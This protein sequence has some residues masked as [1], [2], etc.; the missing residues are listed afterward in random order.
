MTQELCD[1]YPCF[2]GVKLTNTEAVASVIERSLGVAMVKQSKKTD[3]ASLDK[4]ALLTYAIQ[5]DMKWARMLLKIRSKE[6]V[7]SS[8]LDP[9]P[10]FAAYDGRIR[11]HV[12]L[13]TSVAGRWS[14]TQPA[15][16]TLPRTKEIHKLFVAGKGKRML[17]FD[18][19][20]IELRSGCSIANEPRMIKAYNNNEDIHRLTASS[21]YEIQLDDVNDAQ[22]QMAKPVNFSV[23]YGQEPMGLKSYLF[24]EA[25]IDISFE[26]SKSFIDNFFALYP[27]FLHGMSAYVKSCL[28]PARLYTRQAESAGSRMLLVAQTLTTERCDKPSMRRTKDPQTTSC[29][30]SPERCT[31]FCAR[32][33]CKTAL[34]SQ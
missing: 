24:S 19:S 7:I 34:G 14:V 9:F 16:Q 11:P 22:R 33:D 27:E 32:E 23:M 12:N 1:A 2:R 30:M 15:L 6:K 31:D 3:N 17:S 8:Y 13:A 29:R 18:L 10:K 5:M 20:Q 26:Q 28:R 25:E 21:I 4:E